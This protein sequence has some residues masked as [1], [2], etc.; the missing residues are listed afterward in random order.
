MFVHEK[1]FSA[2]WNKNAPLRYLDKTDRIVTTPMSEERKSYMRDSF[3]YH[4]NT[5]FSICISCDPING[6]RMPELRSRLLA[7]GGEEVCLPTFEEDLLKILERGQ[8][9]FGNRTLLKRGKPSRCH[10]NSS[11]LWSKDQEKL[12]L[13]TGY[14]LSEDGMWRQHSW[15]VKI[16][17]KYNKIIETTVPRIAYYGFVMDDKEAKEFYYANCY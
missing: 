11:I 16:S 7:L 2:A 1:E 17:P 8:L 15:L 12:A 14:A 10:E 3:W 13:C 9:W 6:H 5:D 4:A